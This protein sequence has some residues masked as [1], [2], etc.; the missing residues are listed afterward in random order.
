M[1]GK[2]PLR[3]LCFGDSNTW[4]TIGY[5]ENSPLPTSR[6]DR[7]H[8]WTGVLQAELG[9]DFEIIEEGL[10]GRSTIYSK[11]GF[12]WK[13]GE[14]Y[15]V[16]CMH[17]HR[18]I[19]LIVIMLGTNDLQISKT[20]AEEDLPAGISR[21]VD[22]VQA[23]PNTG[24]ESVT[25]KILLLPPI[26]VRPSAPGGRTEVFDKFRREIGQRLS[27]LMP[28]VY[29]QVAREK[30]CFF[31]NTQ[32][33]AQPGRADGV[34]M[35]PA[36]HIRLGKSLAAY[37]REAVFPPTPQLFDWEGCRTRLY[38]RFEKQM[39]SAQGMAVHD[40]RAYI[41]YDS[42]HCAVHALNDRSE[43]PL[44]FFPLGSANE[45]TPSREYRNH[46]N[47]AMFG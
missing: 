10:G 14:S 37:I 29:A 44:D 8:R 21:L 25:P 32:S 13:S 34:H 20:I 28:E 33:V 42:G 2:D 4:G 18:P 27:L 39:R 3:I 26:E 47:Q 35:D 16:P 46:S 7:A 11:P 9:P 5:W 23:Y 36:S 40:D 30:G 6:F 1:N 45:G 12:E 38:M 24:R 15:L 31:F 17:S 19:D 22:L 41:L 43:K